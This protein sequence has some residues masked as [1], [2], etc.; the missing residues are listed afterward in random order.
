M[1]EARESCLI[2][3][4]SSEMLV[5]YQALYLSCFIRSD[6]KAIKKHCFL[7]CWQLL[8]IDDHDTTHYDYIHKN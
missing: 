4:I 5:D 1:S 3:H 8:A 6:M 2:D 7:K